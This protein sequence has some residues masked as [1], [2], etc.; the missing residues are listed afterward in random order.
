MVFSESHINDIKHQITK[1]KKNIPKRNYMM[2]E[3]MGGAILFAL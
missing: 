1:L 2:G 3:S